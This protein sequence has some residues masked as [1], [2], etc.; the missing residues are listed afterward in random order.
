MLQD[1]SQGFRQGCLK[2]HGLL[3]A[4]GSVPISARFY[5]LVEV[6]SRSRQ[7]TGSKQIGLSVPCE[8]CLASADLEPQ[9]LFYSQPRRSL[10]CSR[11]LVS[12]SGCLH[13]NGSAPPADVARQFVMSLIPLNSVTAKAVAACRNWALSRAWKDAGQNHCPS[14]GKWLIALYLFCT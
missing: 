1:S 8:N 14:A 10:L 13:M 6:D 2:A 7:S 12:D 5:N 4:S 9:A 3:T 11:R